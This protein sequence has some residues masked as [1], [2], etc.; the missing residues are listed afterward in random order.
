MSASACTRSMPGS[1]ITDVANKLRRFDAVVLVEN[2]L[3]ILI[4]QALNNYLVGA[5]NN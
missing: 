1:H 3:L 4:M 5:H 2:I